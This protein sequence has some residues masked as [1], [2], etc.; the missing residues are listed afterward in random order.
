[1]SSAVWKLACDVYVRSI[2]KRCAMDFQSAA[3]CIA[4]VI[5]FQRAAS[6]SLLARMAESA[7]P[8]LGVENECTD[9]RSMPAQNS[10]LPLDTHMCQRVRQCVNPLRSLETQ[11][12]YMGPQ[13]ASL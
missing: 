9:A 5:M 10:L 3:R 7:K 12:P 4:S 13:F 1:M 2:F 8:L 6:P 11:N